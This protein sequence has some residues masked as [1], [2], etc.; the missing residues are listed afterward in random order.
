MEEERSTI[1]EERER[2]AA[3]TREEEARPAR[4]MAGGS[5]VEAVGGAAAVVLAILGLLD[6]LAVPIAAIAVIAIGIALLVGGGTLAARFQRL[7][8]TWEG[9]FAPAVVSETIAGGMSVETLFGAAGVALGILAL[10]DTAPMTLIPIAVI[11]FGA[12]LLMASG[13]TERL[14][15][16]MVRRGAEPREAERWARDAVSAASGSEVLVGLGG[17]VLGILAIAGYST[18]TLSLVALL[19]F[20][21]SILLTGTSIASRMMTV[22]YR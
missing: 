22:F 8:T 1:T 19:G 18:L 13:A 11:I 9:R 10:L 3:V 6:I 12:A 4:I 14:N 20:G 21:V 7:L 15:E 2:V 16:L 17:I 5:M